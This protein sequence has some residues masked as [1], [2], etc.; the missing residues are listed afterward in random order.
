MYVA[1][2]DPSSGA[3]YLQLSAVTTCHPSRDAA[4][5]F[6]HMPDVVAAPSYLQIV[7]SP[8]HVV[9][10]C[11]TLGEMDQKNADNWIRLNDHTDLTSNIDLQAVAEIIYKSLV[12]MTS[13][14]FPP[15]SEL[16]SESFSASSR[17]GQC[18]RPL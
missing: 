11:A 2:K 14:L 13:A 6:R 12:T 16:E 7:S 3:K 17:D 9:F 18:P 10:V 5:A 15:E 1:G 8:E 4:D